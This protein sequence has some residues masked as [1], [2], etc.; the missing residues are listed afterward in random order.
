MKPIRIDKKMS[1]PEK[2]H[3][4][5]L[6]IWMASGD[7]LSY[8]Y[9]PWTFLLSGRQLKYTPDYLVVYF[10]HFEIH[11]IKVG[12]VDKKT[13]KIIPYF[14]NKTQE[15]TLKMA[16]HQYPWFKFKLFWYWGDRYNKFDMREIKI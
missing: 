11:E 16:A 15:G 12:I 7:I 5:I 4:G 13:G 3:Q 10:D 9:E 6:N 1:G 2:A 14:K 8:Q